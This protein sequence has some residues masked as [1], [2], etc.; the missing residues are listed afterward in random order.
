MFSYIYMRILESQPECYDRGIALLSLGHSERIKRR[1][2]DD[3]V[4]RSF[5][6]L[7]IGC[8][9][10]TMSIL[11]AQRGAHVLGFDVSH[12][13]IE[14]AQRKTA[15]A[16]LSEA[17]D[18]MEMGVSG[19]GWLAE[20]SLDLVMSTL[21]FSELSRV[22]RAYALR[23]SYRIL[24]PGGRIAIADETRPRGIGKRL[25]HGAVRIPLLLITFVLTQRATKAVEGLPELVAETGFRIDIE[26]RRFLGSFLY[27][28]ATK[29]STPW[30]LAST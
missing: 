5:K 19:M 28:V 8:G 1:L 4:R 18:V 22:E 16:G 10:G 9:T 15:A 20:N 11:A 23:Q 12:A 29:Q 14:I 17:V 7:E 24:K 6:V 26:E 2:V 30:A 21:V 3:N 25:L 27:L 13:M